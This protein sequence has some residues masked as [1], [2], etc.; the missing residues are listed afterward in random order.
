MARTRGVSVESQ[1]TP[2]MDFDTP[3]DTVYSTP[4]MPPPQWT[5]VH[6][7]LPHFWPFEV[8]IK[9]ERQMFVN[10]IPTRKESTIST[11][12]TSQPPTP[13]DPLPSFLAEC[14]VQHE[15]F[16]SR[17]ESF[18]EEPLDFNFFNF[19]HEPSTPTHQTVI[20]VDECDQHLL[21]HFL[22]NVARL[23]FP[24]LDINQHGSARSDVILPA[25]ESNKCYL[26][27]CLSISALHLKATHHLEG[28]QIDND[29]MRH[30]VATISELCEA[31]KHD[32]DHSQILEATLGM[33]LFQSSVGSPDDGLPDIPW[34]EHFQ[35]ATSLVEKLELHEPLQ[36]DFAPQLH[37]SFNMTLASWIDILGATMLCRVPVFAHTYRHKAEMGITSGLAELMGCEDRVMYLISEI[38]CLEA[39]KLQGMDDLTLC[40]H[41]TGLGEQLTNTEI[42]LADV[43]DVYSIAT[44][45]MRPKQLS[46]NITAVFRLAARIHLCS[47]VPDFDR[48]QTSIVA[49]VESLTST[50]A[51]IPGGVDGFDRSL[52]WPLLVAGSV[53]LEGSSFRTMFSIRSKELCRAAD[54]GSFGRVAELLKDIWHTNAGFFAYEEK[55]SIH[56]RDV[57]RQKGRDFLLI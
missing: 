2:Q 29:I 5:P 35:A 37:P 30:R 3:R 39:L 4:M 15:H 1:F 34:H 38:A 24:I 50:M 17:E 26:H 31:F 45:V 54:F 36:T 20:Q 32:K 18:A 7:S 44:H 42:G 51:F 9:T 10:D 56:W 40:T 52:V 12:S 19:P 14:W 25:L 23:I 11:F 41:I 53:S 46:K 27:C 33:I 16:E 57:M 13:H 8:D 47:L 48:H 22:E 43:G 49:L 55:K 6:P 28:E 21:D